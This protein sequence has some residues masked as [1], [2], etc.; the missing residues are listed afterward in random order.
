MKGA[1]I[2]KRTILLIFCFMYNDN[3]FRMWFKGLLCR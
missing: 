1:K 3:Y 2:M